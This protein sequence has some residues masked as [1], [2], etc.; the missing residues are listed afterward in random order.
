MVTLTCVL[1]YGHASVISA[2]N[3]RYV[4]HCDEAGL[5]MVQVPR[6]PK[7][8]AVKGNMCKK[9]NNNKTSINTFI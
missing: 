4:D 7:L 9:A 5:S 1:Y 3:D 2:S 8:K 6:M